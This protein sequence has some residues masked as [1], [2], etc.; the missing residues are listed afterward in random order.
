MHQAGIVQKD[1]IPPISPAH[2]VV[3]G[4]RMIHSQLAWHQRFV[5]VFGLVV[6]V[7]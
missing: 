4:S 3:E 2:D 7:N 1:M 6:K 5:I